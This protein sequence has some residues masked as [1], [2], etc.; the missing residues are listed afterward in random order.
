MNTIRK[1]ETIEEYL[2]RGGVIQKL[3]YIP[4]KK[5]EL[6]VKS[7]ANTPTELFDITLGEH[8]FS[9]SALMDKKPKPFTGDVSL[10]PKELVEFMKNKGVEL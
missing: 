6:S 4:P 1:K 10:L 8:Y 9:H 2:A 5:K 7:T 3:E